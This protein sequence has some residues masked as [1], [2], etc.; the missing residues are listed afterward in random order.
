LLVDIS[1]C[2]SFDSVIIS[3]PVINIVCEKLSSPELLEYLFTQYSEMLHELLKNGISTDIKSRRE[4]SKSLLYIVS[5]ILKNAF[6][7]DFKDEDLLSKDET[8]NKSLI[9]ESVLNSNS[10]YS[11]TLK[12]EI[13]PKMDS[14]ILLLVS[15]LNSCNPSLLFSKYVI[16]T[17]SHILDHLV[18][19][20]QVFLPLNLFLFRSKSQINFQR[21]LLVSFSFY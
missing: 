2:E 19:K 12:K 8:I 1:E 21:I 4:I 13:H 7:V 5:L 10:N 20:D 16:K 6:N 15:C 11:S 14:I 18:E 3:L 17:M 9:P